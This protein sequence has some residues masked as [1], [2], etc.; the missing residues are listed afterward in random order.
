MRTFFVHYCFGERFP[1]EIQTRAREWRG[2]RTGLG[3]GWGRGS[4]SCK[5]LRIEFFSTRSRRSLRSLPLFSFL[6]LFFFFS[7][8]FSSYR[9]QAWITSWMVACIDILL[10]ERSH[11]SDRSWLRACQKK[12]R[13][14]IHL[15]WEEIV[16]VCAFKSVLCF[17]WPFPLMKLISSY[18]SHVIV[19]P[20]L[21]IFVFTESPRLCWCH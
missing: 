11:R 17:T 15:R 6:P 3:I 12:A 8:F 14:E 20:I 1:G 13:S 21:T 10:E 2:K 18:L 19:N 9:H 5:R 7:Y 16:L 4:T